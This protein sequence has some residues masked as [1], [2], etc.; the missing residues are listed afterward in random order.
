MYASIIPNVR[1][2]RHVN[3]FDYAV[4]A[5][6][7]AE[8]GELVRI[9]FRKRT[10]V[11]LVRE[12][13]ETRQHTRTELKEIIG[14]Y[15]GI[16]LNTHTLALLQAL[17]IKSFSSEPSILH[18]WLGR[19]PKTYTD[20]TH[21]IPHKKPRS[22]PVNVRALVKNRIHAHH[23]VIETAMECMLCK[24]KVLVIT[25][26]AP[27]AHAIARSLRTQALTSD[28]ASGT[29]YRLWSSFVH[30]EST[31]VVTTRLGAWLST[32]A[33]VVIVEEPENDDHKQ[34]ELSPRYDARWIAKFA[35]ER[36]IK[37]INI[38]LTPPLRTF[39]QHPYARADIPAIQPNVIAVDVHRSDWSRIPS[40]Q[41]RALTELE[42]AVA[43][44]RSAYIIHPIHGD[45]ARLRCSDCSWQA[46]CSRCGS[47]LHVQSG[48]LICLRCG[49][50]KDMD[51]TCPVCGSVDLSKSKTGRDA[52][53]RSLRAA[54]PNADIRILSIGEWNAQED[55]ARTS[56]VICTDLALFAGGAEDMRRRERL[57]ISFRRLANACESA[58]ATLA[59]QADAQLLTDAKSWL[60]SEG[61]EDAMRREL[62]ERELFRLP[63]MFRLL[64]M[65]FRGNEQHARRLLDSLSARIPPNAPFVVSGPFPVLH[66]PK[67]RIPRWIGHCSAPFGTSLEEFI[68]MIEPL[69]QTDTILDLD[70]VS[71]F[72]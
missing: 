1:T 66:R 49:N 45:R 7:H 55:I 20:E 25:P 43:Q 42:H 18:A 39:V 53:D 64:K 12:T 26:W 30:N 31:C 41:E 16:T 29:R 23:G 54:Y 36:D 40:L 19:M 17:A 21:T 14:S 2:P 34:D 65:I 3:A 9:P 48:R 62:R 60:T 51:V 46:V 5:T 44:N 6:M 47:G 4:P 71:F 33:D 13:N 8:T 72:E 61:C 24:A 22:L 59:V 35:E 58:N 67:E 10:I 38:G 15:N 70:P 37:L 69:L 11:G 50:V 52:L 68:H 27:R 63:P 56:L 28:V 32:E 57:I